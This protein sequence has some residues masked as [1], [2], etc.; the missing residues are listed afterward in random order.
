MKTIFSLSL[1]GLALVFLAGC[2]SSKGDEQFGS[3]EGINPSPT[4]TPIVVPATNT[5]SAQALLQPP[6]DL[7]T[8]GPGDRIEIEII[9]SLGSRATTTVGPD[10]RI[11]YHL[12]P[13]TDVWGLTLTQTKTALEK[14]L[15]KYIT[16]PQVAITLRGIGSKTVWLMGR[17]AHPGVY[18]M[19]GPMTLLEAFAVAGGTAKS[20]SAIT[21]EDLGDL[22]HSFVMREG[23]IL[24]VD[25][26]KL[27]QE[28][29]MNQ[30]IYL[31][32]D[33]MVYVPSSL[34]REIY[35][36]GAVRA[37][38]AIPY[39]DNVTVVSAIAGAYGTIKDA[40]LS[41]VAVVR[42]SLN[43]PELII[44]NY[45]AIV[46]GKAPDFVLEPHDIVYVPF[47]PYRKLTQYLEIAV[48][49]FANTVA[50]NEG[51]LLANPDAAL[52]T[53]SVPVGR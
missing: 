27:L 23:Q 11:Y 34:S 32:P 18:S 22:R 7:F 52:I 44:V 39:R 50:A 30:N 49:T 42:G 17:F 40:Y 25:V 16:E 46:R 26:M 33:D 29:D 5:A 15:T 48:R 2:K 43:N 20:V 38:R 37:P 28:G 45:N 19:G 3:M 47:S 4:L 1:A 35:V 31:R 14:G 12:L 9:G 53:P 51:T 41:H 36:L 10:G 8:L 13:G 21:T 24:P 6:T